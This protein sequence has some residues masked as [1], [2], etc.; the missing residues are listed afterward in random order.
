MT[1]AVAPDP[2]QS[3]Y[4]EETV[5]RVQHWNESLFSFT[6]TRHPGLRFKTG[7][8][9]M[10]GL[11]VDGRPLV[12]AYS[13]ASPAYADELEF[14]SIKV[15]NGPLTSRLQHLQTGDKVLIGRKPTGSL[16]MDNLRPGKRLFLFAS[17][18]GLAPFMGV[19]RD[20]EYYSDFLNIVLL[21][22]VRQVS[23]LGYHDYITQVLPENEYFGDMVKAQLVYYPMVTREAFASHGRV[24]DMLVPGAL[25]ER[26]GLSEFDPE[27]DRIMIC[28]SPAMLKDTV[29]M[30]QALGFTEGSSNAPA[31]YV[32][33]RAF[34]E[35]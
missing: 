11:E 13:I 2:V 30:V 22:G 34:V 8:F 12:R 33:E 15:Q 1:T 3:A 35:R 31:E 10:L 26:L 18:T 23:E 25:G 29:A 28:G 6:T 9:V 19:I 21:H 32:I 16:I 27:Y 4:Y 7:Q 14:Y 17:G 24:T 5:T 20:P